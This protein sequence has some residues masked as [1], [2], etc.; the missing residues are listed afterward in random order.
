MASTPA[1]ASADEAWTG[2]QAAQRSALAALVAGDPHDF[3]QLWDHTADVSL[4]GA[5]GG[6]ARGWDRVRDRL[7]AVA[8]TYGNGVYQRLDQ[9]D[10]H[11]HGD[12]AYT[13]HVEE[14][15]SWAPGG[16]RVARE[17]R[18]TKVYRRTDAGW[19]IVHMHADPLVRADFPDDGDPAA[20]DDDVRSVR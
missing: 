18:V 10:E 12:M 6:V 17:R 20:D 5:F 9:L 3:Q 16:E 15:H 7:A 8:A 1:P 13:V 2:F 19:R 11:V 14:I 4:L